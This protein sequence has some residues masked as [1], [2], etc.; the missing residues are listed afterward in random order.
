MLIIRWLPLS[1]QPWYLSASQ[2]TFSICLLPEEAAFPGQALGS[3]KILPASLV[4]KGGPVTP[5]WPMRHVDSRNALKKM[6]ACLVSPFALH[7]F[8]FFWTRG[9]HFENRRANNHLLRML[10]KSG[11]RNLSPWEHMGELL[12]TLGLPP[13]K[14]L[15]TWEKLILLLLSQHP[16]SVPDTWTHSYSTGLIW[17]SPQPSCSH[18]N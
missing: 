15:V 17:K 6:T 8:S 16:I 3:V 14:L 4:A 12:Y 2:Y 9:W 13:S 11:R 7:H 5:F 1:G 10:E 18:N